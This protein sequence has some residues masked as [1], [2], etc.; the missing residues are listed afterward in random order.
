ML[1]NIGA[2]L[3][4]FSALTAVSLLW[5]CYKRRGSV[6]VSAV[7][8]T[9]AVVFI[10]STVA[11]FYYGLRAGTKLVFWLIGIGVAGTLGFYLNR[12]F[13]VRG[14]YATIVDEWLNH[15]FKKI[16]IGQPGRCRLAKA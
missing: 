1:L 4:L 11:M 12:R 14:D 7:K 16:R 6:A 10:I 13:S 15:V 5:T 3:M 8:K 2:I 9:A